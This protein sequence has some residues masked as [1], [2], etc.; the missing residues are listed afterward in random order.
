MQL[1]NVISSGRLPVDTD[2]VIVQVIPTV[3]A[4]HANDEI[5]DMLAGLVL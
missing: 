1:D 5:L 4:A 3:L 2:P